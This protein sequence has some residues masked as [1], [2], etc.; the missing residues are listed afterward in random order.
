MAADNYSER[1]VPAEGEAQLAVLIVTYNNAQEVD[2]LLES[3][4]TEA[5]STPMR[6]VVAD[7]CSSDAT[8]SVLARHDDVVTVST[9]GNLGYA[10]GINIAALYAGAVEHLLILNPDLRVRPG[11][12]RSLLDVM[13]ER[14]DA[15][16]VA[17]RIIGDD[18]RV[19]PSLFN[20]PRVLRA[21][22]D[23]VLGRIWP[24][25]PTVLT[26]WIRRT[27][28][29]TRRRDVDWATGAAFLVRASAART[30]GEWDEQFFLYSEETDF[31]RRMR[32]AGH[33]VVFDPTAVVVH[34]QGRSGASA[35]LD[36]L[37][38]VNRVRYMRKHAPYRAEAYRR[39]VMLGAALRSGKSD[40]HR[41]VYH[42]LRDERS[43]Q[44]LPRG[45]W[46][47]TAGVP[48]AS[49]IVPAHNESAVIER[50]LRGLA[51]VSI[52]GSLD[53]HV[54]C[55]GCSDDTA[56]RAGSV[57]GVRVTTLDVASKTA[58]INEGA[59]TA[60]AAPR[61]VLDADIDLPSAA[62][63]GL[64]RALQRP[65]VYAG[66]P[67]FHYDTLDSGSLV[68]AYYRARSRIPALSGALWGA[69]IYALTG[70]GI[71]RVGCLPN[72]TADDFYVDA[73]FTS[74]EKA[75]PL[76]PP[77]RVRTP[78]TT[79][80]L[81]AVL[82]R[83]RRGVSALGHDAGPHT[84]ASVLRTIRGPRS[85]TDAAVFII[86]TG[87]GRRRASQSVG[88]TRWERDDSRRSGGETPSEG[89][90]LPGG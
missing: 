20:E 25:R 27:D 30:V 67:P 42:T 23:A 55:N 49:V 38:D 62:I 46:Q 14:P 5:A 34:S 80:A 16:I 85:L 76:S 86:L 24:G 60:A 52:A 61:I 79:G 90:G 57:P 31:C 17:P 51:D 78:L 41:A 87:L 84:L 37:L 64:L 12:V 75:I 69:G 8:M 32:D 47:G 74:G 11:A 50:T 21:F 54:I 29:Y 7:N 72:V 53:I 36:A 28:A 73:L 82:T 35:A 70:A 19:A 65:G 1:F 9:G 6:V 48:V 89:V 88:V 15:G 40:A 71:D 13:R 56:L 33:A 45:N 3:L 44:A 10:G 81:L 2:S 77:V 59:R 68:R 4:R 39:V 66:R 22:C 26:E 83:S 43:W 58:A 63:P 18:G